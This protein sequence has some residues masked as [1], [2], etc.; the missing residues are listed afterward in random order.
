MLA[1]DWAVKKLHYKLEAWGG[2]PL[3]GDPPDRGALCRV[4]GRS[5]GRHCLA[6]RRQSALK[7]IKDHVIRTAIHAVKPGQ[8]TTFL[9]RKLHGSYQGEMSIRFDLRME[10]TRM[11][12]NMGPASIKTYGKFGKVL[13]IETTVTDVSVFPPYGQALRAA[14]HRYL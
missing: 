8:I 5:G 6:F 2:A 13:S 1:D 14:N 9:G 11:R 7:A 3:S 12:H 4:S 10:G